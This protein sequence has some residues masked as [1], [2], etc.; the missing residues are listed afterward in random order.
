[1]AVTIKGTT[2]ADAFKFVGD[3]IA[4]LEESP[5]VARWGGVDNEHVVFLAQE[6]AAH[7]QTTPV[8]IRK[9]AD[10]AP[11]LV[12][13]RHRR[14][15]VLLINEDP[16]A[17]G[18]PGPVPL[19]AT[20]ADLDEEEAFRA[21]VVENTGRPLT[22]MDLAHAAIQMSKVLDWEGAKI[23]E[24]LTTSFRKV[25]PS[26]VSQLKALNGLPMSIKRRLHKGTLKESVARAMLRLQ[27]SGEEL[28]K[29][30]KQLEDGEIKPAEIT[31]MANK[32]RRGEGKK[33]KRSLSELLALL[34]ELGTN[35]SAELYNWLSGDD[36]TMKRLKEIFKG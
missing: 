7:S 16:G 13:G 9:R 17:Y 14:A 3:D 18:L 15:A 34:E 6:I 23:A 28:E 25:S 1:M 2:R 4:K 36:V 21:S 30:A 12:A 22:C 29:L 19:K 35:A 20:Y 26:R 11:E 5:Q 31:A 8:L 27:L 10:G 32:K 33:V 24:A